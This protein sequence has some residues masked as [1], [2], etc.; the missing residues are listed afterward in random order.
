MDDS[1]P[2]SSVSPYRSSD[3]L[4]MTLEL[5]AKKH[6][7]DRLRA[8]KK[9]SRIGVVVA[10][11]IATVHVAAF[12]GVLM[13]RY[14]PKQTTSDT[15]QPACTAVDTVATTPPPP[16]PPPVIPAVDPTPPEPSTLEK[17]GGE[18]KVA[19]LA[20]DI[21]LAFYADPTIARSGNILSY[22]RPRLE[23]LVRQ[24]LQ[25][26]LGATVDDDA[27]DTTEAS[28]DMRLTRPQYKAMTAVI[29]KVL[30]KRDLPEADRA[31]LRDNFLGGESTAVDDIPKRRSALELRAAVGL[32]CSEYAITSKPIESSD[33][34]FVAGCGK[35]AIYTYSSDPNSGLQS[36]HRDATP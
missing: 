1:A 33:S 13:L 26:Y 22:G 36:W 7:I 10:L 29:D 30:E 25:T 12:S 15:P 8:W 2:P 17:L 23:A 28:W 16:P 21:T 27:I 19:P 18:E 3:V 31:S 24:N 9:R 14:V 32:G 11:T 34:R 6:E 20:T 4:E 35:N 5:E